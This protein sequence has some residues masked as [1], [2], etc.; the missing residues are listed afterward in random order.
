MDVYCICFSDLVSNVNSKIN[1]NRKCLL[2][3]VLI[4][5]LLQHISNLYSIKLSDRKN[6]E[7]LQFGFRWT[8][9][10]LFLVSSRC[11]YCLS[12]LPHFQIQCLQLAISGNRWHK[13]EVVLNHANFLESSKRSLCSQTQWLTHSSHYTQKYYN[14]NV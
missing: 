5:Q 14:Y 3:Q 1:L 12:P 13:L 7:K 2:W 4:K 6:G 8:I 11:C 10:R 9:P